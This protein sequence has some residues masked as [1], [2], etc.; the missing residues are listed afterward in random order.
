MCNMA[1]GNLRWEI[2]VGKQLKKRIA[3]DTIGLPLALFTKLRDRRR[4]LTVSEF[5][6]KK[7][8]TKP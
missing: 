4:L 6:A 7:G 8:E 5:S 3:L 1:L 2:R